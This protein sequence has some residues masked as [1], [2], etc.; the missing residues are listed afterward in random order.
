MVQVLCHTQENLSRG[1]LTSSDSKPDF[2]I[3]D[4][5]GSAFCVEIT[6]QLKCTED[7]T[8]EMTLLTNE[9]QSEG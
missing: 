3:P 8:K 1:G 5:L 7:H 9:Y 6:P 2:K 4:R